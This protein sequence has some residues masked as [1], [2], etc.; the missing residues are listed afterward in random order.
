MPYPQT[1]DGLAGLI[2]DALRV[3]TTGGLSGVLQVT[4]TPG[5]TIH[6]AAGRVSAIETPG[7]PSPEVLL[8]R[9]QRVAEADWDTAYAAAASAGGPMSTELVVRGLV[10]AGEM[11][12]LLRTA[13]ADAM[14]VLASGDIEDCR[15]ESRPVEY[16]L[17]LYPAAEAEGLRAEAARRV[18]VLAALPAAVRHVGDRVAAAPGVVPSGLQLGD[19]QDEILALANGRRTARDLA[20]ALGRGV[21]ATIMQLARMH[22]AGLIVTATA[23]SAPQAPGPAAAGRPGA[24]EPATS[25]ARRGRELAAMPRRPWM[26]A[27][28]PDLRA[29]LA[30]LRS[31]ASRDANHRD[32][33]RQERGAGD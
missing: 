9:S 13:L 7:A 28:A 5:G 21:F 25:L 11:E 22:Q 23:P 33:S 19:G 16:V 20:F 2:H 4:G 15:T 6:F 10:G 18:R 29:S 3:C 1:Q 14:F 8:L 32:T 26:P 31:R 17:P 12:A 30:Q 24:D 27:R